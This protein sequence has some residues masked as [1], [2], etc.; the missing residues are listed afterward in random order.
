MPTYDKIYLANRAKELSVVRDTFEKVLR[1][2][3]ILE[4]FNTQEYLAA[5]LIPNGN[6]EMQ[7]T[8]INPF[9][10]PGSPGRDFRL[11]DCDLEYHELPRFRRR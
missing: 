1:L 8:A 2:K 11:P 6:M 5:H 10:S 4:Y 9:I 7:Q 3:E